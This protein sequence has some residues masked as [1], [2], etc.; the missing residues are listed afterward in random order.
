MVLFA[1]ITRVSDGMPST[2]L[3][4]HFELTDIESKRLAKSSARKANH[5]PTRCSMQ[6]GKHMIYFVNAAVGVCFLAVCKGTYPAVLVFCFLE[7]LQRKFVM[8]FQSQDFQ[9]QDVQKAKRPYSFIEFVERYSLIDKDF[10]SCS[11]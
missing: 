10:V 1:M 11:A 5:Y 4:M 3:D 9:S 8:T 2:D 7:E 6:C